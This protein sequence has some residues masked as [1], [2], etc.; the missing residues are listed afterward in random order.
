M[1][2]IAYNASISSCEKAAKWEEALGLLR[3]LE[4]SPGLQADVSI[5]SK[6]L[7]MLQVQ[8]V[9]VRNVFRA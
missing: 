4:A 6:M 5:A 1:D 7:L 3:E 9:Q 2:V 8:V